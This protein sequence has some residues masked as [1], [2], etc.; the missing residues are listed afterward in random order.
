[1]IVGWF[2]TALGGISGVSSAACA[3]VVLFG[4]MGI[5][6]ES[7]TLLEWLKCNPL[8]VQYE[9]RGAVPLKEKEPVIPFLWR[10]ST[11]L[12]LI[13]RRN[14]IL[15]YRILDTEWKGISWHVVGKIPKCVRK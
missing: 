6:V 4:G 2:L 15:R 11:A 14:V 8:A 12:F 13:S 3:F 7:A 9:L 1:M 10:R 5:Y